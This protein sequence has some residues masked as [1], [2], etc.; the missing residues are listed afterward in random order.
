MNIWSNFAAKHPAAAKWVREGGLFVI[1]SNVITVFKYLM[2][3]FLPAA[4]AGLGDA[5]FG[6]PGIPITLFGETFE[7]NILGY[8]QAHGGLAYFCAYMVAM[9]IGECINFPIQ[10][11]FVFRSKGKL[12][13]QIAWYLLAFCVI[14]CI[15]NSI[16]C[17]WVAVAGLLVPDFIYNI[18][19]TVLNGGISMI[20]FFFVN[21][22][23]FP[24]ADSAPKASGSAE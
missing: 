11:N 10:R 4:F 12:G 24:S 20:V 19:T 3:Q 13:P 23:I 15:V 2:L 1:V 8:D 6:W 22:I 18:G 17:I 5:S 14:T 21:K 16:N 9:V 7:W